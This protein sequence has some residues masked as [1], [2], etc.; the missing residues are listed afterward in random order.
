MVKLVTV[1]EKQTCKS[2]AGKGKN[3]SKKCSACGGS[4]N[5][6]IEVLR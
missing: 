2:C 6:E 1:L 5:V 4:G 3:G